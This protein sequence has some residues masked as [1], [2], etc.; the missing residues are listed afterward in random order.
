MLTWE[1]S[2]TGLAAWPQVWDRGHHGSRPHSS[3]LDVPG[4]AMPGCA[5]LGTKV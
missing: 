2:T 3:V 5:Q 4:E 1:L